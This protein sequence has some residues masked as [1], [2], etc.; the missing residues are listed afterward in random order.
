MDEHERA[1]ECT[2]G[3]NPLQ[4]A[5]THGA[6]NVDITIPEDESVRSFPD[7]ETRTNNARA[8]VNPIRASMDILKNAFKKPSNTEEED[9][10]YGKEMD[11][12]E[13]ASECTS[14]LNP[15]RQSV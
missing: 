12:H 8:S 11:E 13:R 4:A 14:G 15:L 3:M 1:S 7:E 5:H 6:E 2:S 10:S 9:T